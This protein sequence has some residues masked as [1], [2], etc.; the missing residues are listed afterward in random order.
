MALVT[1]TSDCPC[2][3]GQGDFM[4]VSQLIEWQ[5]GIKPEQ[6]RT[7]HFA[8][9]TRTHRP[10]SVKLVKLSAHPK[11]IVLA[12]VNAAPPKLVASC[13]QCIGRA[14]MN[15]IV[16]RGHHDI[17]PGKEVLDQRAHNGAVDLPPRRRILRRFMGEG[18]ALAWIA[19]PAY[20]AM[21]AERACEEFVFDVTS[22]EI[23]SGL[24]AGINL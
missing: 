16:N 21:V 8:D 7:R 23:E 3:P 17:P 9:M 10:C 13:L 5:I 1:D 6:C 19:F 22:I 2:S 20:A 12:S 11:T 15:I 24:V 18:P 4:C 14:P